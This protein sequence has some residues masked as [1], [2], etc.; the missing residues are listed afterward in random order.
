M[1][2]LDTPQST[3]NILGDFDGQILSSLDP[4]ECRLARVKHV[5]YKATI[6]DKASGMFRKVDSPRQSSLCPST[7]IADSVLRAKSPLC[8]TIRT[9][10]SDSSLLSPGIISTG[11]HLGFQSIADESQSSGFQN[12]E[13][14]SPSIVDEQEELCPV[15]LEPIANEIPMAFTMC[16]NHTFHIECAGRLE[17]PQCPVC[18]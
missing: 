12:A 1:I 2:Q 15:C 14:T 5:S 11:D 18:R 7:P 17:G 4:T 9:P 8:D 3:A 6:I 10:D 13:S 16:C